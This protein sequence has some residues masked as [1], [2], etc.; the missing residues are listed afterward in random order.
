MR[1]LYIERNVENVLGARY[2]PENTVIV[3]ENRVLRRILGV[4]ERM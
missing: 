3:T 4:K 1:Y 2:L